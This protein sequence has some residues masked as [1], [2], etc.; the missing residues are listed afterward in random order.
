[1]S[2]VELTDRLDQAIEAILLS[3][4]KEVVDPVVGD[5][6]SVAA[7]LRDLPRNE[8]KARLR[9]KLEVLVSERNAARKPKESVG[10]SSRVKKVKGRE[11]PKNRTITPYLVVSDVHREIDF[12]KHVFGA[13]GNV[14]GLGSQGGYHSEFR[15][16]ESALMIGGGGKG[17]TWKGTPVPAS[18]HA[19]VPNVDGVYQKAM[20]AGAISLMPPTDMEYGERGAAIE[21]PGGNHWYLAT[22]FGPSYVPEGLPD[23]MP[24]FNPVGAPKM[25]EFLEQALGA[26]QIAA[27]K[28]PDGKVL[29]AKLRIGNSIVEMGEAHGQWQSRP[30]QFMVYVD[31]SDAA[32]ARAMRTAGAISIN[33]PANAAYG[34]RTGTIKDPWG[35]TWY[36]SSQKQKSE[37]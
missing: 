34:G 21:D 35:N 3:A 31:D 10:K 15:I 25:I 37:Q 27:H 28:T 8:F 22:A 2:E 14:Y 32:F 30:M 29:H 6:I 11:I 18:L 13:K 19:Y 36:L 17:A 24:F 23:V 26:E 12:I 33:P 4:S 16:G 9:T 5:L 1:M 7:D 20:D